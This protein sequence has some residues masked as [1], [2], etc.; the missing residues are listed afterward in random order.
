LLI[1]LCI[2]CLF[3]SNFLFAQSKINYNNY[4][5][6]IDKVINKQL[7]E[8]EID[9]SNAKL[10]L[11]IANNYLETDELDKA[12]VI[13]LKSIRLDSCNFDAYYNYTEVLYNQKRFP[14]LINIASK[15]IYLNQTNSNIYNR[16]GLA[17]SKL[18]LSDYAIRCFNNSIYFD[19]LNYKP[20]WS[21]A[22]I[23]DEYD[24]NIYSLELRNK[25]IALGADGYIIYFQRAVNKYKLK[26][27]IGAKQDFIKGMSYVINDSIDAY[28]YRGSMYEYL[29]LSNLALKDY[30]RV[31]KLDSLNE[32]YFYKMS[33]HY[34]LKGQKYLAKSYLKQLLKI[35]PNLSYAYFELGE[36]ENNK[37]FSNSR[38]IIAYY[39]T[40]IKLNEK[41]YLYYHNRG[42]A[43]YYKSKYNN[44]LLDLTKAHELNEYDYFTN[45][46]LYKL[47][48]RKKAYSV[49]YNH[50]YMLYYIS[51]NFHRA[52]S[53]QKK[54]YEKLVSQNT[55]TQ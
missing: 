25:A 26:D 37:L 43:Y 2:I 12:E 42:V 35:N 16:L 11:S 39:D 8:L 46:Y 48:T 28:L 18:E 27:T 5:D 22:D 10:N 55:K 13:Y 20:Y 38:K 41:N 45:Y 15:A 50:A 17:Q 9:S 14:E 49:A 40:A 24:N 53:I 44:A 23:Y 3:T 21:L 47:Y 52:Y 6:S 31:N 36:L 29:G 54:A 4:V 7:L 30:N 34:K 1:G 19:S 32:E 51:P 33:L